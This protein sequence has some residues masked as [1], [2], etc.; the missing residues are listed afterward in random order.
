MK[1]PI[2][3][4]PVKAADDKPKV[5]ETPQVEEKTE[6]EYANMTPDRVIYEKAKVQ[7]QKLQTQ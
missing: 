7:F 1:D 4:A 3:A 2:K 6:D 5:K